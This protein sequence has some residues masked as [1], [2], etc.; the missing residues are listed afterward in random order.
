MSAVFPSGVLFRET[1]ELPEDFLGRRVS[2]RHF[3]V[4]DY[5]PGDVVERHTDP[6]G[7][8]YRRTEQAHRG[9]IFESIVLPGLALGVDNVLG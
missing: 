6:S 9:Q 1:S 4:H 8:G 7:D 2:R 5:H 3:T